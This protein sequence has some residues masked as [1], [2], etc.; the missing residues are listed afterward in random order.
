MYTDQ[1][2]A[3]RPEKKLGLRIASPAQ[4]SNEPAWRTVCLPCRR[5]TPAI[6]K[7]GLSVHLLYQQTRRSHMI[8]GGYMLAL[9]LPGQVASFLRNQRQIAD[10]WPRIWAWIFSGEKRYRDRV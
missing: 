9:H 5:G 1:Y 7:H 3:G 10:L 6:S 4:K 2:S 8:L